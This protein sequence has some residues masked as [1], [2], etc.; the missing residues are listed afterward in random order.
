M[1]IKVTAQDYLTKAETKFRSF[2][3]DWESFTREAPSK[4]RQLVASGIR[5]KVSGSSSG[6]QIGVTLTFESDTSAAEKYAEEINSKKEII[7]CLL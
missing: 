7:L 5:P 6:Y 4:L 1:A 2:K 3:Q